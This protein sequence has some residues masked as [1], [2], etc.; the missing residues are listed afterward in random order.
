VDDVIN[1]EGCKNT[2]NKHTRK[3]VPLPTVKTLYVCCHTDSAYTQRERVFNSQQARYD[4]KIKGKHN[5]S[6][7]SQ[8]PNCGFVE[9]REAKRKQKEEEKQKKQIEIEQKQ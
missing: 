4:H 6:Q 5:C 2:Q 9:K 7:E 8:C 1:C 3:A